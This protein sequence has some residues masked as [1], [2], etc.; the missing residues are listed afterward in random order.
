MFEIPRIK[1]GIKPKPYFYDYV[2]ELLRR[3]GI[4]VFVYH[5]ITKQL[6]AS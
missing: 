6:R 1:Q 2:L 4:F 5:F 3:C